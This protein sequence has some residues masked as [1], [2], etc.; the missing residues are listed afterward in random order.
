M[1]NFDTIRKTQKFL[2]EQ[3]K[4]HDSR[5]INNVDI[6]QTIDI[7]VNDILEKFGDVDNV[8]QES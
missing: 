4:I 3:A 8:E 2:V 7:M 5:I 6:T 1:D